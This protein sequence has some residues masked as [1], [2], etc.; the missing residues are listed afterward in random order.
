MESTTGAAYLARALHAY[1]VSAVFLVPTMLSKTLFEMEQLTDIKRIVTHSEKAAAYMADGYAR[2][3]GSPG[4]CMAQTIGSANLAAGLRDA[5]LGASPVIAMT[6]GPYPWSRHRAQYQEIEDRP[7]FKEVAKASYVVDTVDRLPGLLS[8]AFNVATQGRPGPVHLELPGH[9]GELIDEMTMTAQL[10]ELHEIHVPRFR[11]HPDPAAIS[12][13]V[14]R[15]LRASR[16]VIVAGGGTKASGAAPMLREFAELLGL[17]VATSLNGKDL[18]PADHPLHVGI[19]GLYP[20]GNANAVVAAADLVLFIGSQAGSQVTL[21]WQIPPQTTDTIHVDIDPDQLGRHYPDSLPVLGDAKI[22]LELLTARLAGEASLPD[23]A[24]W[25][26]RWSELVA[27]W[28]KQAAPILA[29]EAEPIR[30]E[31]LT[32]ELSKALPPDA[33]VVADTGH[34]GMWAGGYLDLKHDTQS[35]LRAA[36]SLGWAL[37]ASIGAKIAAPDRPVAMFTGDGGFW[38]HLSEIETAAR[39]GVGVVMVVNNN[40]SLNQEIRP[41]TAAYGGTLHG[42]HHELWHFRDVSFKAV[43]EAMGIPAYRVEKPSDLSIAFD[44]AFAEHGPVIVEV[45]TDMEIMAPRGSVPA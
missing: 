10:P 36:G 29:S 21:N 38:Y 8:H 3:K 42:R 11:V 25:R 24:A 15:L 7:L 35:Y 23:F 34:A 4:I 26:G 33:I 16:P 6:G 1:G 30:P 22:V 17:P 13:A 12:G 18:L 45:V 44:A 41:F 37:P 27:S 43:G 20:S 19:P 39:W 5:F 28:K 32:S 40:N 31:R 9:S 2:T 14:E